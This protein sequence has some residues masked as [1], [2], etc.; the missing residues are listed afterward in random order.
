MDLSRL[1]TLDFETTGI[2][3]KTAQPVEIGVVC[4]DFEYESFINPGVPI[5]PEISAVHHIVDEDVAAY[6]D[7]ATV[8]GTFH[9]LLDDEHGLPIL[10]AHN[11]QYEKDILGEFAPVLWICTYKAAL[12]VWPEAPNHKNETL[13]YWLKLGANRGRSRNQAAHSALHDARVTFLLLQ[14]LLQHAT[15]EQLIEWTEVPAKLPRMP[16]GKHFGQTWDTIPVSY[17][18]WIINQA[19][20]RE[21]VKLCAA[22]ELKLRRSSNATSRSS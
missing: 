2:D 7:W 6:P 17:L 16:M 3:A 18:T 21:D 9:K 1:Y 12:R 5:P 11:A 15:V 4:K 13:R 14:E 10:V 22:E 20:M 19:D 8:K